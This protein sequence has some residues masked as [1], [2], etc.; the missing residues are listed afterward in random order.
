M[1]E[2]S[3]LC[4][5]QE[6]TRSLLW[7]TVREL[8]KVFAVPVLSCSAGHFLCLLNFVS[9]ERKTGLL[10]IIS[11]CKDS[12]AEPQPHK[13]DRCHCCS[14]PVPAGDFNN[15]I[16]LINLICTKNATHI[17][18]VIICFLGSNWQSCSNLLHLITCFSVLFLITI[19]S[20]E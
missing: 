10:S 7:A 14:S 8:S 18:V 11:A 3:E 1:I 20:S 19:F 2:W 12:L 15:S 17:Y 9:A 16:S 13:R 6:E 4:S 5:P